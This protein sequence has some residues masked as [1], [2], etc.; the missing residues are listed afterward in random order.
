MSLPNVDSPGAIDADA[1]YRNL[2]DGLAVRIARFGVAPPALIGIHRGGAWIAERLARDLHIADLGFLDISFYRDDFSRAGLHPEV[3]PTAIQFPL[4][5]R[6]VVLVD[7]VL[8]TGRTIRAAMNALFDFGRPERIELA[9]LFDRHAPADAP[10]T[11]ELP[12][13]PGVAGARIELAA[14][15]NLR[16]RRD[17]NG[18]AASLADAST[19]AGTAATT[20]PPAGMA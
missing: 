19:S 13:A 2:R 11:R 17:G 12:V 3:L 18:F 10:D 7:D 9:V 14:G 1:A 5:G 8:Y 16:L 4:D 6:A 20:A 15:V